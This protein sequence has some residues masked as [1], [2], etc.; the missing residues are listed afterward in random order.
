MQ[1]I[2][3]FLRKNRLNYAILIFL[4]I[5]GMTMYKNIPKDVMPPIQINKILISGYYSAASID[6]LNK[7]VVTQIEKNI[8]SLP[9]IKKMES[10]IKNGN[11]SIVLTLEESIDEYYVLNKVRT[12]V[13]N[14]KNNLPSDMDEPEVSII[15]WSFP[16]LDLS[17]SSNIK[18]HD[19]LIEFANT[20][21][22][23]LLEFEDIAEV[24][25]YENTKRIYEIKFNT[26]Q[27]DFYSLDKDSLISQIKNISYIFPI[28]KIKDK[29]GHLF[30]SPNNGPKTIN[31]LLNTLIKIGN[32][33]IYISDIATIE[34]KYESSE[35]LSFSN[36]RKDI[37]LGI[38]KKENANII[39]LKRKIKKEIQELNKL[40]SNIK[41]LILNDTSK[42]VEKRLNTVI[43]SIIIGVFIIGIIA[44]LLINKEVAFIVII[45]V[46]IA[47]LIGIIFFSFTS[48]SINMITLIGV[49]LVIGILVDDAI[50]IAENI[51]RHIQK[52]EDK[53]Q[54][55]MNGT[56]EMV[57]P[58]FTASI[59]TIFAFIPMLLFSGEIGEFIKMIPIVVTV[60]IIASLL[61][62]FIFLPMHGLHVLNHK[63]REF[64]W[65]KIF[66]LYKKCLKY[67]FKY[68]KIFTF[69]FIIIVVIGTTILILNMRYQ[70][71]SDFDADRFYINGKFAANYTVHDVHKETKEIE[72]KLL[73]LKKEL[74]L[75]S[76]SHSIG[77]RVDNKGEIEMKP[78]V[79]QFEIELEDPVPTNFIE[80][81][82]TPLFSFN[83]K[84]E[85]KT[86][87]KNID[88][89]IL[90]LRS[91]LSTFKSN[92][93]LEFL[94][95]KEGTGITHNAIE[96]F[97][98]SSNQKVLQKSVQELQKMLMNINGVTF[99]NNMN[100]DNIQELKFK[101]N[102]Y[103]QS[104]GFT[105]VMVS[106]T[107]S[108]YYLKSVQTKGFDDKGIIEFVTVDR[109]KNNL[110]EL[111]NFELQIENTDKRVTI[112]EIVDFIFTKTFDSLY[113][114]NGTAVLSVIANIN[115]EVITAI[116]VIDLL[117]HKLEEFKNNGVEIHF[118][119]EEEQNN[120]M[121]ND[122]LFAFAISFFLIFITLLIMF[123]SYS[124][125]LLILSIIPFSI[126]GSLFGHFLLG[127]NF[128]LVSFVGILGLCGVVV[129][130][131]II[132]LDFIRKATTIDELIDKASLRLRAIIITS[133]TTFL[134]LS[135]L[136]F[137]AT[138]QAK[139]LQPLAVSLGFGLLWGT[140]VTLFLLPTLFLMITK[141][142]K[143]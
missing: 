95:K 133:L 90:Y 110:D 118:G 23:K 57:M 121:K 49:L 11:F 64:D 117:D 2:Q 4:I 112:S 113:K 116:E 96:I 122:L 107:L 39:E 20:L 48:L 131:S 61:E 108:K 18:T 5:F 45:G 128:T 68:S 62:S 99:V 28:G 132:M 47:I 127:I 101:I 75:K 72:T 109:N 70:M 10:F 87:T 137:F 115:N 129:N 134:G 3:F 91:S 25:F 98:S 124:Y 19:E 12:I 71:L 29:N 74:G 60:L 141:K 126:F 6:N 22:T 67:I 140:L 63:D 130:N 66:N 50:I 104:L 21:K 36:G 85:E 35:I 59:T 33:S 97:L 81:Y 58:V 77:L 13:Q 55:V 88:D 46:P 78:S 86:R 119:G 114:L 40:Y 7:I 37:S 27:I 139:V 9:E 94:I 82:I 89:I 76:I 105:E 138:G 79:F 44:F 41:I 103:G 30:L 14:N 93:L 16:F 100:E 69:T 15:K 111:K 38:L 80:K 56:K 136:I 51:Q 102:E 8:K 120:I 1:I 106:S 143:G 24:E 84:I 92:D 123:N 65:S 73:S 142:E 32:T 17:I 42:Q 54:S 135:I 83:M 125:S 34:K 26:Q 31:E 43:S 53:F 52:G